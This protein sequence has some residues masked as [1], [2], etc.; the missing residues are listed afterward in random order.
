MNRRVRLISVA[1][2]LPETVRTSDD[3]ESILSQSGGFRP[4]KGFIRTMSGIRQRRVASDDTQCSDLAVSACRDVLKKANVATDDVDLLIYASACQD[5]T[6]PATSHLVQFKL[7]TDCPV[8]DVKNA[9]N[10]FLNGVQLAEALILSGAYK[11]IL[12]AVGEV[13]S[14]GIAWRSKNLKDF[15]HNMPGYTMGDAGAAALFASSTEGGIY[16]RDFS[17]LSQHWGLTT[18]NGGGSMHP[19]GDEHMYI[20]SN[21]PKLKVAFREIGLPFM[22]RVMKNANARYSDFKRIFVHQ[23]SLPYLID[24]LDETGIPRDKVEV[25]IDNLGNIAAASIPVAMSA[26]IDRGD[27]GRGDRVMCLGLASGISI[28]VIMMDL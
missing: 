11:T 5:L 18:V 24:M 20:R 21:A 19:R 17:S 2:S 26:A 12:V 3:I 25:T 16:F 13:T 1:A 22:N 6:E 7:G 9:C 4:R 23:I 15:K 27:V 28:G 10:S 8:F 14:R